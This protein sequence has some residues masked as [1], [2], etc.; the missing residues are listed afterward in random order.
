MHWR[1]LGKEFLQT[2][3]VSHTLKISFPLFHLFCFHCACVSLGVRSWRAED[4]TDVSPHLPFFMRQI[5]SSLPVPAWVGSVLVCQ[6]VWPV[7]LVK[8][9]IVNYRLYISDLEW[10]IATPT[11]L[12]D[13]LD[14]CFPLYAIFPSPT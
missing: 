3:Q 1:K 12:S 13:F 8:L 11:K 9:S 6:Q 7:S 10:F 2:L 4:N 5:E 14:K